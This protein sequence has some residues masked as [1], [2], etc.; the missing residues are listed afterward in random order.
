[1]TMTSSDRE[2][3][4]RPRRRR[5][6]TPEQRADFVRRYEQTPNG[7]KGA[8]LR[9][10]NLYESHIYKWKRAAVKPSAAADPGRQKVADLEAQNA[11]LREELVS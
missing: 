2:A 8:F 10:N 4:G 1:M 5:T 9:E 7:G 3:L 6:F 11:A